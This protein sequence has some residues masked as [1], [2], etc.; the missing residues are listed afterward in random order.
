MTILRATSGIL[1]LLASCARDGTAS[2]RDL[3]DSLSLDN[4]ARWQADE[5]TRRSIAEMIESTRRVEAQ[6]DPATTAV[7]GR[8]LQEQLEGLIAGCTMEGPAHEALHVY[9]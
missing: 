1:L 9:H 3:L 6:R 4:G 5:H 2:Q 8:E 7:L